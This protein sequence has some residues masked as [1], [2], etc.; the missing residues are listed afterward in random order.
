MRILIIPI[1]W[2]LLCTLAYASP[3]TQHLS[4]SDAAQTVRRDVA[5]MSTTISFILVSDDSHKADQSIDK[6]VRE[7]ERIES[8]MSEWR[9]RSEVSRINL[10]AGKTPVAIS[11]ELFQLLEQSKELGDLTSGKFDVTFAGAGKL[12]DFKN[13]VIPSAE[14]IEK[15]VTRINYRNLILDN[16]SKSAF[17]N[18]VDMK[19]G[20]GGIAKGYAVDRA[21]QIIRGDGFADFA[22]NAGGDLYV[23]GKRGK[24]LW[25]IGIQNPRDREDIIALLPVSNIAVAT[26]G[27]YERYFI[28]EGKRYNHII[29]PLTG[30]PAEQ[31][32]SVTILAPRTYWADALAT[33]VFVLGPTAGLNLIESLET[34]EGIIVDKHGN[35]HLSSGLHDLN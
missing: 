11:N 2:V 14:K 12:W 1:T 4:R 29:D 8:A 34:I 3:T 20:L 15:A 6:A 27:D 28:H 18:S 17:L 32:R 5:L 24:K 31:C 19:L 35:I 13:K 21:V 16:K 25:R 7:F 26:S 9:P 22:V 33:G 10:S 30:H 23:S